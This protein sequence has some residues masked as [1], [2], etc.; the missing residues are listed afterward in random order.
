MGTGDA[1]ERSLS[2]NGTPSLRRNYPVQVQ[3]VFLS[4]FGNFRSSTPR[5]SQK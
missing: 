1:E 4:L 2:I 3:R 5:T